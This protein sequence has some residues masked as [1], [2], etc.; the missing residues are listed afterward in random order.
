MDLP[1]PNE[2][3]S[4]K[5]DNDSI[6]LVYQCPIFPFQPF[7]NPTASPRLGFVLGELWWLWWRCNA[8]FGCSSS[9]LKEAYCE[10]VTSDASTTLA[11]GTSYRKPTTIS[12]VCD[13]TPH[14][15]QVRGLKIRPTW[16]SSSR[17]TTAVVCPSFMMS[18][19]KYL[20]IATFRETLI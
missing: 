1:I 15:V 19:Q 2:T 14:G 12:W 8:A 4:F 20:T 9:L 18:S 5:L 10:R 3:T 6:L 16:T 7:P 11:K 17:A 13:I